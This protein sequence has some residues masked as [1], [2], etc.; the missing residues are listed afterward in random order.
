MKN[1]SCALRAIASASRK[2]P[3]F[4]GKWRIADGLFRRGICAS[5][6]EAIRL[7]NGT[8]MTLDLSDEIDNNIWWLGLGYEAGPT[9]F[10]RGFLKSGMVFWDVGA[11]VG[12]YTLL[13]ASLIGPSGEVRAFEPVPATY[14]RL[15][16]NV[17]K[18]PSLQNISTFQIALSDSAGTVEM[19][20]TD[21]S[22]SGA[23]SL[24]PTSGADKISGVQA[25]RIDDICSGQGVRLPEV[26]KID[27]EGHELAVLSGA[28]ETLRR[29]RPRLLVE[30][31]A[32]SD[33][34]FSLLRG[35]GYV[36]FRILKDGSIEKV[37]GRLNAPL[38]FFAPDERG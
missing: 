35:F 9:R 2:L 38:I 33:A 16:R 10:L 19:Y 20:R 8:S 31:R 36:P 23:S 34:I 7:T 26:I 28:N 4:T 15:L 27:V 37:Y 14:G 6:I 12:Y 1:P 25:G 3:G 5:G 17:E 32:N 29:A 30:C 11:N 18:N 21:S 24:V 13:V 22:N